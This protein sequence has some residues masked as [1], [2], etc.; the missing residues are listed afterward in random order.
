MEA[1]EDKSELLTVARLRGG[2]TLKYKDTQKGT[3]VIFSLAGCDYY[4]K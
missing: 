1:V 3:P 2:A 4:Q